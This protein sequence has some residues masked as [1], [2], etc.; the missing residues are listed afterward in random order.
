MEEEKVKDVEKTE[1]QTTKK[2]HPAAKK[3]V[4]TNTAKMTV[5]DEKKQQGEKTK[6]IKKSKKKAIK[7]VIARGK[8]KE[9]IA[10]AT[11][12]EGSGKV[13]I[14]KIALNTLNNKYIKDLIYQPLSLL[15]PEANKIDVSVNVVGGGV[16]GQAQAA[17]TAIAKALVEYFEDMN[18][19][20]KFL[21][22]D[23]TLIVEDVRRV[24]PKKYRGPKARARYQKSYR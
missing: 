20:E 1:Q 3:E 22:I 6:K 2:R 9:S 16:M 4:K 15:G 24:E 14:N 19:K 11:V 12:K 10:R 17:R 5:S 13:R 21:S 18:L 7:V 8:R 23:R